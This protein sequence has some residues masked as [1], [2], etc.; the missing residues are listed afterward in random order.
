MSYE[1][2]LN[3]ANA[4]FLDAGAKLKESNY[5]EAAAS[6]EKAIEAYAALVA[7]EKKEKGGSYA[8]PSN[9]QESM[10]KAY[11]NVVYSLDKNG[12]IEDFNKAV[13]LL[14]TPIARE[15]LSSKHA[16]AFDN[17]HILRGNALYNAAAKDFAAAK[18]DEAAK[19]SDEAAKKYDEAATKLK[20]C[21]IPEMTH[22]AIR[23]NAFSLL[24]QVEEKNGGIKEATLLNAKEE[25]DGM[26]EQVLTASQDQ[27]THICMLLA[28]KYLADGH[29]NAAAQTKVQKLAEKKYGVTLN[30]LREHALALCNV[31][32]TEE[33]GVKDLLSLVVGFQG[34]A[35]SKDA[36]VTICCK[37]GHDALA[38]KVLTGDI[39]TLTSAE[40]IA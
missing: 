1:D 24:V 12:R 28:T 17:L 36:L 13:A 20:E 25:I 32:K 8:M 2:K 6:Y 21:L 29:N 22:P 19:K 26:S 4:L 40:I 39:M 9:T 18:D 7:D 34:D 14:D 35:A 37:H 15:I 5:M 16:K 11:T 33:E 23:M 3:A 38:Q 10:T 31:S 27:V 30:A